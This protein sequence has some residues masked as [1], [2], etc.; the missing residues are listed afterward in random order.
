[1][2]NTPQ[3]FKNASLLCSGLLCRHNTTDMK[4]THLRSL[5]GFLFVSHQ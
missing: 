3:T 2:I 5:Q 1:M 4:I